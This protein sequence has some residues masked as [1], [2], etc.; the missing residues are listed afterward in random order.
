MIKWCGTLSAGKLS[1]VTPPPPSLS[2]SSP[3][4]MENSPSME[5]IDLNT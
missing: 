3:S 4:P 5:K 1:G 2:L